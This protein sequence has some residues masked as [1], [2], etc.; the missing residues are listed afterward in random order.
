[1]N[2][3]VCTG[4]LPVRMLPLGTGM[5]LRQHKGPRAALSGVVSA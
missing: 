5:S 1:M 4:L 3:P 2:G